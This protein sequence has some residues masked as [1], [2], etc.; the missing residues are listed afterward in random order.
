MDLSNVAVRGTLK[1]LKVDHIE[2]VAKAHN[3]RFPAG[4]S[5]FMAQ[6]G[7]GELSEIRVYSPGYIVENVE[8]W[9]SM[10]LDGWFMSIH[11]DLI[12]VEKAMECYI[13]ADTQSGDEFIFHPDSPDDIYVLPR[14]SQESILVS[15]GLT[16]IFEWYEGSSLMLQPSEWT[17]FP[18]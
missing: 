10:V 12:S 15:G 9:R 6:Y 17:F 3:I 5:E 1:P 4:Y 2:L 8:D 14:H 7:E 18:Y 11:S 13:F 16:G